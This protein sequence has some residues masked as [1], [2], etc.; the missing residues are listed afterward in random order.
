M[1]YTYMW[2][3]ED[4]TP[5]YVGKGSGKRAYTQWMHRQN[6]PPMGRIVFYIAKDEAD[7]FE[8]EKLLIWYYGRKDLGTGCL[9]NLTDGGEG[10]TGY[11]FS[12]EKCRAISEATKLAMARPEIKEKL[13]KHC[14]D[15]PWSH[16]TREAHKD[17]HFANSGSFSKGHVTWNAGIKGSTPWNKGLKVPNSSN[18][19]SFAKGHVTW[20][21]GTAR[22][23]EER[24]IRARA[25]QVRF[26]AKKKAQ[27][28]L[29][30]QSINS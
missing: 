3:R 10:I 14:K 23:V 9:R 29:N 1:F 19:G 2:L 6:P 20:N 24:R 25:A 11:V 27:E 30:E 12:E 22:S 13:G 7:A 26:K 21:K 5:Y 4:G 8:I 16:S 18:S 17:S 15:V 28:R